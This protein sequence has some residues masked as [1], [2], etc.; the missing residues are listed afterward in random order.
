MS[1][2]RTPLYGAHSNLGA[3]FTDFGGWEMPVEFDSIREEHTAV[4]TEVGVFDVSHMGQIEMSGP[5]AREL[6]EILTTGRVSRLSPGTSQYTTI[7][8]EDGT[9]IDDA[10]L[11]QLDAQEYLLVPNAGMDEAVAERWERMGADRS[12]D[13]EVRNRTEAW[14]M[15]AVQGPNAFE[16]LPASARELSRGAIGPLSIAG[17]DCLCAGTGYTGESGVEL[18]VP[19]DETPLVYDAIDATPSGLGARDTLRLEMGYVLAGNEFDDSD[20]R[21]TPFEAGLGFTVDLETDPSCIAE[22]ALR[23]ASEDEDADRLVG[24]VLQERGIPRHGYPITDGNG[25]AIG[26]VTS[27]TMSP[28][29]GEPVGLGYVPASEASPGTSIGIEIRGTEKM[30]SIETPP[31]IGGG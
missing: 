31:F 20:N 27:G 16:Q 12:L 23:S 5:D 1:S 26:T 30:A 4:R 15:L 11:Y 18:L 3:T 7:P 24:F 28:T 2:R 13:V 6:N 22:D 21:R 9:I 19:W 10:I 25:A 8:R 14:G 17:V 29:R